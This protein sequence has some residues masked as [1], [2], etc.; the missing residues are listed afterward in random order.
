M[1]SPLQ[2]LAGEGCNTAI[3]DACVLAK[4]LAKAFQNIDNDKDRTSEFITQAFEGFEGERKAFGESICRTGN[5]LFKSRIYNLAFPQVAIPP[6]NSF[7]VF[8]RKVVVKLMQW[9][10]STFSEALAGGL[11]HEVMRGCQGAFDTDEDDLE[12]QETV[13]RRSSRRDSVHK[14]LTG[15][16]LSSRSGV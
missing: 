7:Q 6:S 3:G 10:L 14:S 16:R 13:K 4:Y 11:I 5:S 15:F 1:I 9:V 8:L 2:P 12:G